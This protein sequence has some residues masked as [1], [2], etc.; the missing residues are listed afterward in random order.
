MGAGTGGPC[1][2]RD[3]MGPPPPSPRSRATDTQALLD[4]PF[5]HA[6]QLAAALARR[7]QIEAAMRDQASA[8]SG[9]VR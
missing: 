5:E 3:A 9:G 6:D 1:G 8:D 4:R 7:Q 2:F